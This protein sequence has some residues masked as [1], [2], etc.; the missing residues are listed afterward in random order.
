[1]GFMNEYHTQNDVFI[2]NKFI[3]N[4]KTLFEKARPWNHLS[5]VYGLQV[6]LK[7]SFPKSKKNS[8]REIFDG[9][10]TQQI[11]RSQNTAKQAADGREKLSTRVFFVSILF[12][13]EPSSFKF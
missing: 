13:P 7:T 6:V 12:Y 5:I 4:S 9:K 11:F 8:L 3:S 10:R 2:K 1:M